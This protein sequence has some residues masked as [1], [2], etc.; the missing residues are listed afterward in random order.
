M[1]ALRCV[2]DMT[3]RLGGANCKGELSYLGRWREGFRARA[4]RRGAWGLGETGLAPV[5][6]RCGTR[7][8]SCLRRNDGTLR[9]PSPLF[10]GPRHSRESGNLLGGRLPRESGNLPHSSDL[11]IRDSRLRGNDGAPAT[12]APCADAP[13]IPYDG[14]RRA[15]A[16]QAEARGWPPRPPLP[17]AALVRVES[18]PTQSRHIYRHSPMRESSGAGRRIRLSLQWERSPRSGGRGRSGGAAGLCTGLL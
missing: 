12:A 4:R 10:P 8:D 16:T 5:C 15:Q 13:S 17:Q 18:R 2:I 7:M 6:G 9:A 1:T 3:I 14:P 11:W